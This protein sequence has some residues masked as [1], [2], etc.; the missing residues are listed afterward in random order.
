MTHR[1][2]TSDHHPPHPTSPRLLVGSKW[3]RSDAACPLHHY[4]V[5]HVDARG[6]VELFAVLQPQVVQRIPW[7]S[8]R[9][10]GAWQPG[11]TSTAAAPDTATDHTPL[12]APHSSPGPGTGPDTR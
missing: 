4:E 5:R 8:L 6:T 11:W 7:R 1:T 10:R 12:A 9:D 2:A 3:T